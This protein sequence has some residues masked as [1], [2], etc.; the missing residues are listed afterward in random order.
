MFR[1][2]LSETFCCVYSSFSKLFEIEADMDTNEVVP[3]VIDVV[4]ENIMEV[5]PHAVQGPGPMFVL[6][7]IRCLGRCLAKLVFTHG[8]LS[9]NDL[10]QR[11]LRRSTHLYRIGSYSAPSVVVGGRGGG[12]EEEGRGLTYM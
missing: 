7:Q 1:A 6:Y 10:H 3:D 11:Y 12:G 9:W 4:P 2:F 5:C 8:A